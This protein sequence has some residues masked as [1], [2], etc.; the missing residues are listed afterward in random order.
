MAASFACLVMLS[1]S[2]IAEGSQVSVATAA[3]PIRKVV[4]MLQSMQK[5]VTEEGEIEKK[6]FDK[7]M[8]YC[9]KGDTA[10]AKSISDAEA[11][12]PALVSEIEEAEQEVKQL[13]LDLEAHKAD[14]AAAKKSMAEATALREEEASKF[15]AYKAEATSNIDA[16]VKATEAIEKGMAG[17]FLQTRQAQVLKNLVL[18]QNNLDDVAREEITAFLSSSQ[19]Y[20]P[21]SGQIVGILKQMTDTFNKELDEA[22]AAEEAAIKAY[23]ELMAAKQKEVEALTKAIEEKMVRLGKVQ[24]EIVEMKED[25]DDTGKG[26][27]EDKKFLADLKKNCATKAAEHAEN[28][29]MR[30]QELLALA[31]TIKVLNDDDALEL[32]KKTLPSS[33]SFMQLEVTAAQ[34]RQQ[35]L[36]TIRAAQHGH[37]ELS[38]IALALQGKKVDFGKIISMIDEMVVVLTKEQQ[39]DNDKKEYCETQLDLADDKKRSLER[40]V[41][42]LEKAIAK[43]K[44]AIQM[45]SDEIKSLEDGI[46]ALDKSVAE[47]TEQRKEENAE[48]TEL[49]ANDAAAKE[50]LGF[51]KNR[52][53]KFYNPKLYKPPPKRVLSE[54][55]SIVVNMGGTLAPTAAPGGI[56]GTGIA[57]L[58]DVSAHDAGKVA[59][60]PPPETA[61]AFTKKAEESNGVIGMI[62]L[63]IADLTKEMTEAKTTE[64][65]AQADYEKAMKDAAEKRADD[66][67]NLADKQKAKAETEAQME[68]DEEEKAGTTKS[69]MATLEHIQSLHGECDWLLQYFEVRKEARTGEI[70]SL[71]NAKAVLSGADYSLLEAGHTHTRS[72]RGQA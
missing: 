66:T 18:G 21:A 71:K 48:F 47:A 68:A 25:L 14:R 35:A 30:S 54:E 32:F 40:S 56:A 10:L 58:V 37:P 24:V 70:D 20:A 39:S 60:P 34:Q 33:S 41:S 22:T 9:E 55:D 63:L 36:A 2:A 29:K 49:M 42:L 16:M 52:L 12:M 17:S 8:C 50:L 72:L 4:T 51:A 65:D 59:P 28:M 67:Q 44:E 11:K 13:K 23:E 15:A 1:M 6:L 27:I 43:E 46:V 3:N 7:F 5:K 38:F 57:A 64:L 62:D 31:D 61:A 26:L 53:N 69:L 19:G 45:L